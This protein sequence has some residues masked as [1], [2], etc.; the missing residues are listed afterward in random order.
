M[1][2]IN[3]RNNTT[4]NIKIKALTE[5]VNVALLDA[6]QRERVKIMCSVAVRVLGKQDRCGVIGKVTPVPSTL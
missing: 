5:N 2:L 6:I 3:E 4:E 1:A